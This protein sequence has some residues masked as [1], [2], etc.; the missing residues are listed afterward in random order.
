MEKYYM[1]NRFKAN[2]YLTTWG[3]PATFGL[4]VTWGLLATCG[5]LVTWGLFVTYSFVKQYGNCYKPLVV[6]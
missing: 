1:C 6:L 2:F 4:L 5:L 3:L